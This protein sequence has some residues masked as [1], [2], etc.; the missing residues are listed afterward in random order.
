MTHELD[1][2]LKLLGVD[3]SLTMAEL[4]EADR[5]LIE[6]LHERLDNQPVMAIAAIEVLMGVIER[7]SAA[8]MMGLQRE[9]DQ[10][11][12]CLLRHAASPEATALRGRPLIAVESGCELFLR[13]VM[14]A[15][16]G[17]REGGRGGGRGSGR[18]AAGG[19]AHC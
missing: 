10:A 18:G 15:P 3:A 6:Q 11:K 2:Y 7:S 13:H 16:D 12:S 4:L 1:T 8:T 9:L 19:G 17:G 14:R 5:V